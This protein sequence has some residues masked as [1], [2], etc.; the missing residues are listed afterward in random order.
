MKINQNQPT[1]YDIVFPVFGGNKTENGNFEPINIFG[2]A[3]YIKNNFYIT[4]A[5]TIKN[6]NEY[7]IMALGF[8]NEN[9]TLSF[10]EVQKSEIFEENDSG[11]LIANIARAKAYPWLKTKLAMLNNVVSTGYAY[12]FDNANSE[13]LIRSYKGHITLVGY[14]HKFP[15]KPAHYE[16]SYMC[17]RGISGAPLIYIHNNQPFICGFTIGNER[18]SIVIWSNKEQDIENNKTS[19]Y[20]LEEALHR[21]IA[22]QAE[23]FLELQSE[24]LEMSIGE[25]LEKENLIK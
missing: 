16:L 11:I 7:E 10:T 6:A 9:G 8:Q 18:T 15:K 24:I 21:G 12:G 23:S 17:P 25:Y 5:H 4:C 20:V 13:V 14:Y 2:T 22:L 1:A 19:E 3:F